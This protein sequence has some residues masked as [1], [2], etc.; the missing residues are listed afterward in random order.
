MKKYLFIILN[1][2]C[3]LAAS[4]TTAPQNQEWFVSSATITFKIKNAGFYVD[5]SFTGLSAKIF[6]DGSKNYGNSIEASL[7]SKSIITGNGSRDGHL[8]KPSYFDIEN[9]PTISMKANLFGKEPNGNFRGHFK[10]TIKGKTKD[11]IIPFTFT[12]KDSKAIFKGTFTINRL[13]FGVGESSIVLSNN[14]IV[15]LEVHSN[16]K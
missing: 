2:I 9:F 1:F 5:G 10:L 14:V 7:D 11:I 12:E 4:Q 8:K 13:D 16:K 6:F 3:F 15:S